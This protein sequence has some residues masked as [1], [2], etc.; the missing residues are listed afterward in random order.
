MLQNLSNQY[1][2]DNSIVTQSATLYQTSCGVGA[3][4][5]NNGIANTAFGYNALFTSTTSTNIAAFGSNALYAL[6]NGN[7]NTAIGTNALNSLV[8]GSNNVAI[9]NLAG[10]NYKTSESNNICIGASV[11]GT[12]GESNMIRIGNPSVSSFCIIGGII[13][14]PIASITNPQQVV[15]DKTTGQLASTN[16]GFS[17]INQQ[18]FTASGSYT[19]TS[20]MK[21]CIVELQGA[22]GG[23]GGISATVSGTQAVAGGGGAGG[24]CKSLY[25]AAQIGAS[26]AITLASGG[27][28]APAG[29]NNG[30]GAGISSFDSLMTAYGGAG[31]S[32]LLGST[33]FYQIPGGIGG[34]V[35]GGII[36]N[37]PG[38]PGEWGISTYYPGS[39]NVNYCVVGGQGGSSFYSGGGTGSG[40]D[41]AG[42][43]AAGYGGGGGGACG[44]NPS[45][46]FAGGN[47]SQGICIVT[48]FS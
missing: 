8:G 45:V 13:N 44:A 34:T 19:P 18:I 11:T 33:F 28:G 35:T 7:G 12:T 3:L 43:S 24:Y 27:A 31:G 47:G 5:Q 32:G 6:I 1:M 15:I 9:G 30:T 14:N 38:N 16:V 39:P 42:N 40:A 46:S 2:T 26:K 37:V 20:T 36:L 22:G 41:G 23:G 29:P 4:S 10:S 25:T 17:S 48:E 21:Y